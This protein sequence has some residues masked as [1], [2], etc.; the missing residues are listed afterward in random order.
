[1]CLR[2]ENFFNDLSE[3]IM[4]VMESYYVTIPILLMSLVTLFVLDFKILFTPHS[5]DHAFNMANN[6]FFFI[7]LTEFL[8]YVIFDHNYNWSFYFY[9]DLLEI[10]SMIPETELLMAGL[11]GFDNPEEVNLEI[12]P[13]YDVFKTSISSQAGGK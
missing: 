2:F 12:Q 9:L 6:V 10:I 11:F 13:Y 3:K 1:M 5:T 7:F 8:I 4:K